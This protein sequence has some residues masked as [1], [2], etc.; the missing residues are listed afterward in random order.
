MITYR[1]HLMICFLYD[2]LIRF[3]FVI[4]KIESLNF[5]IFYSVIVFLCISCNIFYVTVCI[6]FKFFLNSVFKNCMKIFFSLCLLNFIIDLFSILL[7]L[8]WMIIIYFKS[9]L[10]YSIT[11]FKLVSL[12]CLINWLMHLLYF[13]KCISMISLQHCLSTECHI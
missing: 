12:L 13:L 3:W 10:H 1:R 5:F 7:L 11:F 8:V 4:L 9:V 6:V 2:W